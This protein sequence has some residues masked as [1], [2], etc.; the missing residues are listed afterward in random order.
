MEIEFDDIKH[1]IIDIL[2][3]ECHFM[4]SHIWVIECPK[5]R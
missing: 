3:V 1:I 2:L 5:Y 4:L